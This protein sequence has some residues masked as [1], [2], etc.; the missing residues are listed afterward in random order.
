M[1]VYKLQ[2]RVMLII[3]SE[4]A[5]ALANAILGHDMAGTTK[6]GNLGKC[7]SRRILFGAKSMIYY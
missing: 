5:E 4:A 2:Q 7:V 1:V 6:F 3:L